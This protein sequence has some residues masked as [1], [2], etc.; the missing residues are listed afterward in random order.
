MGGEENG[1]GRRQ[2]IKQITVMAVSGILVYQVLLKKLANWFNPHDRAKVQL[3]AIGNGATNILNRLVD[4]SNHNFRAIS[5]NSDILALQYSRA[6]IKIQ[7]GKKSCGGFGS[8]ADPEIGRQAA[9]EDAQ[10]IISVLRGSQVN[11]IIAGL[12][13]GTGTGAGPL[14]A[15]WSIALG[16][17]TFAVVTMPFWFEGERRFDTALEGL[18]EFQRRVKSIYIHYNEVPPKYQNKLVLEAYDL[19]DKAVAAYCNVK[20]K[21]LI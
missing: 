3:V 4:R 2:A 9:K 16:A 5:I 19:N 15:D 11:I 8:G 20:I 14:V 1:I 13:G 18:K 21:S 17:D 7:I 6:D 10:R 12:G